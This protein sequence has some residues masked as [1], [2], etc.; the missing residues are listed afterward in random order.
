MS[1]SD[2]SKFADLCEQAHEYCFSARCDPA[3]SLLLEEIIKLAE[4]DTSLAQDPRFFA[5]HWN[6]G[7]IYHDTDQYSRAI[8][9]LRKGISLLGAE[10]SD[11][12]QAYRALGRSL[13]LQGQ[14]HESVE[15]FEKALRLKKSDSDMLVLLG[16]A[17]IK[18]YEHTGEPE[19]LSRARK[20]RTALESQ[21]PDLVALL[22]R[23]HPG[24]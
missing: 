7:L 13:F 17:H 9:H 11:T 12:Y 16:I 22:E 15:P 1:I 14:Y 4:K 10:D 21:S 8:E 6:L 2:I 3:V 24:L 5:A 23:S 19:Y 20:V 18:T